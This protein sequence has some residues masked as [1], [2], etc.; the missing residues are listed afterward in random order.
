[1]KNI[2]VKK[3]LSV[4]QEVLCGPSSFTNEKSKYYTI[5]IQCQAKV[6]NESYIEIIPGH[7]LP[8]F[9]HTP[10]QKLGEGHTQIPFTEGIKRIVS[11][12]LTS[13]NVTL[14]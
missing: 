8:S 13:A 4:E 6:P 10:L 12:H 3:T 7:L 11:P 14:D 1:M 5:H 2:L 9:N